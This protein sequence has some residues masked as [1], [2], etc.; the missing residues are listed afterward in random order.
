MVKH[1]VRFSEAVVDEI[2][3]TVEDGVF[4]SKSEFHRFATDYLLDQ[5]V[6]EY[7]PETID[8]EEI[9]SEVVPDTTD[10]THQSSDE[11]PFFESVVIVRKYAHRGKISDAEDFIDHHYGPGHPHAMMLEELLNAYRTRTDGEKPTPSSQTTPPDR[12]R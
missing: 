2:T 6:D 5:T 7:T 12:M 9:K 4:E 11:I 8:Y 10:G 1:T 3:T